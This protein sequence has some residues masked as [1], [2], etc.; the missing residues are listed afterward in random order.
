MCIGAKRC[1]VLLQLP[2][3]ARCHCEV[4]AEDGWQLLWEAGEGPVDYPH[5]D[6]TRQ[7]AVL[8]PAWLVRVM[9]AMYGM[10]APAPCLSQPSPPV[11]PLARPPVDSGGGGA[12]AYGRGSWHPAAL[13]RGDCGLHFGG[14]REGPAG[15][16]GEQPTGKKQRGG[17]EVKSQEN[18]G[19]VLPALP[20][21]CAGRRRVL[22][23]AA[24]CYTACK[25][26]IPPM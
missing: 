25:D 3:L 9:S 11:P 17:D 13:E 21:L 7:A 15:Q 24:L 4:G 16:R 12:A 19:S 18:W 23:T 20:A 8:P 10:T 2:G 14:G 26:F 5:R 22:R 6:L 1:R